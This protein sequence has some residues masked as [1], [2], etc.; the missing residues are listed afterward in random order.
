MLAFALVKVRAAFDGQVIGFGSTT[1]PDNFAGV[2]T[3]HSSHI[4]ARIL[5]RCLGLPAK[6]MGARRRVTKLT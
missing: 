4:V 5:N 3:N 6:Y 2:G 1:G